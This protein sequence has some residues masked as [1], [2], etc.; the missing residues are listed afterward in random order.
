MLGGFEQKQTKR[1]KRELPSLFPS[2]SSVDYRAR[3]TV[4]RR[5]VFVCGLGYISGAMARP[6][7]AA[8]RQ[9]LAGDF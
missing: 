2:F 9:I 8:S 4:G 7:V 6:A 3:S 1:T 5:F